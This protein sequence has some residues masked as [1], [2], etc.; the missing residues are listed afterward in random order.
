[1]ATILLLSAWTLWLAIA[2]PMLAPG[3][4]RIPAAVLFV[5]LSIAMWAWTDVTWRSYLMAFLLGHAVISGYA[6]WAATWRHQRGDLIS[7]AVS[8]VGLIWLWLDGGA[9]YWRFVAAALLVVGLGGAAGWL[10][11][12]AVRSTAPDV[13]ATRRPTPG[14]ISAPRPAVATALPPPR[15]RAEPTPET[16]PA[17]RP[18]PAPPTVVYP[19]L[20]G[21]AI[22]PGAAANGVSFPL[23]HNG[24]ATPAG[25]TIRLTPRLF[26]AVIP[27]AETESEP[28]STAPVFGLAR[29]FPA[30]TVHGRRST[31]SAENRCPHSD[32]AHYH[33]HQ[34]S[35]RLDVSDAA[36]VSENTTV[37][38]IPTEATDPGQVTSY[39]VEETIVSAADLLTRNAA[40]RASLDAALAES[41]P[42]GK[43]ATFLR[44]LLRAAHRDAELALLPA[45]APDSAVFGLFGS[46]VVDPHRAVL[47]HPLPHAG[48]PMLDQS[49]SHSA[50]A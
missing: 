15:P 31:G 20:D 32:L 36:A 24:S 3:R 34:V 30:G 42:A 7:A 29:Y 27:T 47:L 22:V 37:V 4:R 43:T 41:T 13:A 17:P 6:G 8:S 49:G 19:E 5:L 40:L 35:A 45:T 21:A 16:P 9:A 50:D 23:R 1:M 28:E 18:D 46:A 48:N 39:V 25:Q 33:V 2:L 12:Y 26:P 11:R 14:E 10:I 38:H 44:D